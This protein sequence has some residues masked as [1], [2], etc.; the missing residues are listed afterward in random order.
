MKVLI[1]NSV[2]YGSTATI[3]CNI[4][5]VARESGYDAQVAFGY[6]YHPIQGFDY[7]K[8]GGFIDKGIHLILSRITGLHG[9]FSHLSTWKF[10]Q[11]LKKYDPDLI[12]IHNLHGWYINI[13][14]LLK[15]INDNNKP[16]VWT[17]HDCWALTGHCPHF[18]MIGCER[19][20][21][22]CHNCP[23]HGNYPKTYI[24]ES[25][26]MHRL[27]KKWFGG[28]NDLTIVTP[29]KW[30][31]KQVSQSY[32]KDK[33]S[34]VIN[35]GINLDVFHP[36]KS[37]FR[38]KYHI[39]DKFII[40]GVSFGWDDKKGLDVF[41]QLSKSLPENYQVILVGTD[42]KVEKILPKEIIAIRRTQSQKD[43]A[44]IYSSANVFANFTREETFPTVN[45][46]A[47]ACGL[48]VITF[49]TGGSPEIID[50]TCGAVVEKDDI[51]ALME[52]IER[53]HRQHPYTA[54]ACRKRAEERYESIDRFKE[55][56]E[57]YK[58]ILNE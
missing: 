55:Y 21:T 57:L 13:P 47:L 42:E 49:K 50:G 34:L 33:K 36:I 7:I 43:L 18:D 9:V 25:R 40:I 22:E 35:N 4:A 48:P 12:H 14:M 38:S 51:S 3:S 6:S 15:Y 29:S 45:I 17:L 39:E 26:M 19:W 11:Q 54:E 46:E 24:D 20:K 37:D 5:K 58:S 10:I 23:I 2:P 32:L 1:I 30:L 41:V 44:E 27:K 28:I 8:I 31:Q 52:E 16:V 53:I 56:I